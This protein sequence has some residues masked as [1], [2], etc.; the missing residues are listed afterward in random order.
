MF[1][2]LTGGKK[3]EQPSNQP[4]AANANPP[5]NNKP[6]AYNQATA[7]TTPNTNDIMKKADAVISEIQKNK[8][9]N[10]NKNKNIPSNLN[11]TQFENK[12]NNNPFKRNPFKN[13]NIMNNKPNKPNKPN[14][15]LNASNSTN[16]S[17]STNNSNNNN[18]SKMPRSISTFQPPSSKINI[19]KNMP[20]SPSP[21]GI[22]PLLNNSSKNNIKNVPKSPRMSF[23]NSPVKTPNIG[24]ITLHMNKFTVGNKAHMKT[25]GKTIKHLIKFAS[26]KHP[27]KF[28]K[29]FAPHGH[30]KMS[31]EQMAF[32]LL[33]L[34]RVLNPSGF[35][36]LRNSISGNSLSKPK[37]ITFKDS[38][39][40]VNIAFT[41]SHAGAKKTN[42]RNN[43]RNN[44]RNN[45]IHNSRNNGN[46]VSIN[47]RSR[48]SNNSVN[49]YSVRKSP[50]YVHNSKSKNL[51]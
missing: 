14:N 21:L 37:G 15:N 8:P 43:S 42:S 39:V 18:K 30:P 2:F 28:N 16:T 4:A 17:N 23:N 19:N 7:P 47:S 5:L 13:N 26:G 41:H 27:P 34:L 25:G 40:R 33:S 48:G 24:T 51:Y 6:L 46:G 11:L 1:N 3:E 32:M 9:L 45:S 36:E 49:L 44:N 22:G 50:N 20:L 38:P 10:L 31:D 29:A 12:P 35:S